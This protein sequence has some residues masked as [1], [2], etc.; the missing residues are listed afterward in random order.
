[1]VIEYSV[2]NDGAYIETNA[3]KI[4][5][6]DEVIEYI[7]AT[8][9]DERVK[10]GFMELFDVSSMKKSEI[11]EEGLDRI[12]AKVRASEKRTGSNKLAIVVSKGSSFERAK[13]IESRVIE[14]QNVI[15]FNRRSTAEIWLGVMEGKS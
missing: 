1:M 3:T 8:E 9:H 10:P 4:L 13:Y 7:M 12:V 14:S 11:D 2:R 15:V 6:T 5:T